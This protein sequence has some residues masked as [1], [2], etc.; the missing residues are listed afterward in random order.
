MA[1][2][3]DDTARARFV[4]HFPLA[5]GEG[6]A[7]VFCDY[8]SRD[9]IRV[10]THVEADARLRGSGAAG[11]F[12]AGL[13]DHLRAQGLKAHPVCSYAVAWFRRHP[14]AADLLA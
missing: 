3:T 10:L 14:E 5:D 4:A 7:E 1:E 6:R 12:M 13:A 8:L 9:D 2:V 11:D